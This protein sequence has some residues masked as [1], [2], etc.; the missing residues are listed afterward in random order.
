MGR[1]SLDATKAWW[2]RS[3]CAL[4]E[5]GRRLGP[6][7]RPILRRLL[8][9]EDALLLVFFADE[10]FADK[11]GDFFFFFLAAT[12]WSE[13]LWPKIGLGATEAEATK[14]RARLSAP[15]YLPRMEKEF[16]E[17]CTLIYQL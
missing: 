8:R 6:L 5:A 16:G 15:K 11:A 2:M 14:T 10:P 7:L 1:S 9:D 12:E 17:N 4:R 3:V 13:A